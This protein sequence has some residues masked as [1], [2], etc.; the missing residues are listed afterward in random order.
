[1]RYVFENRVVVFRHFL[2]EA[3]CRSTSTQLKS[4]IANRSPTKQD[5]LSSSSDNETATPM[6][7]RLTQM[8]SRLTNAEALIQ[9][10]MK[11]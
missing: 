9:D 6:A 1:M 11:T 2:Y 4:F 8:A 7:S 5:F 3:A 10:V